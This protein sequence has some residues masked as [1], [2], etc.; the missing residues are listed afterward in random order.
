MDDLQ[1]SKMRSI[2]YWFVD[3][4]SEIGTGLVITLMGALFLLSV[5]LPD[6]SKLSWI[7]SYGQPVI[8]L[9]AF[10][11]VSRIVKFFK[12][13]V[14][15]PR[16]GFVSY[17]R[18]KTNQRIKRGVL[19]GSAAMAVSIITTLVSG[20]LDQRFTPLFISALLTIGMAVFAFNYGIKR[21]YF[22]ALVTLL[23]GALLCWLDLPDSFSYSWL[24]I[25]IGA[26]MTLT[27]LAALVH[28]LLTTQPAH[29]E[30]L[31]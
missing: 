2:G 14:T 18:P 21:F 9:A 1:K 8:I 31:E 19:A 29:R 23:I 15:F 24:F 10:L 22:V 3:G 25:G 5:H 12:E 17:L 26:I 13:R 11:L 28:Y 6:G 7:I 30:E 4:F 27:G 20:T 16:T